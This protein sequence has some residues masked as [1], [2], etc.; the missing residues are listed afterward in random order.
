MDFIRPLLLD[1]TPLIWKYPHITWHSAE[2]YQNNILE[3]S[4]QDLSTSWESTKI[5][6][7]GIGMFTGKTQV[8]YLPVIKTPSLVQMHKQIF[9]VSKPISKQPSRYF[10]SE[11]WI[12]HITIISNPNEQRSIPDAIHVLSDMKVDFEVEINNI[13]LGKYTGDSAEILFEIPFSK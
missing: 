6:V 4:L 7:T 9:K 3:E 12:P 1:Q 2:G 13:A 5:R 10:Q 8:L 11:I